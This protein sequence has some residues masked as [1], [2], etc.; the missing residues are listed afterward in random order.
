[1]TLA[2]EDNIHTLSII[3][4]VSVHS[5]ASCLQTINAGKVGWEIIAI[6]KHSLQ[7]ISI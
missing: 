4:V 3:D 5:F 6:L 7:L 1:M 2:S